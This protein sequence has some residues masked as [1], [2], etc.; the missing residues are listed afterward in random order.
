MRVVLCWQESAR[1]RVKDELEHRKGAKLVSEFVKYLQ[2][3][4]RNRLQFAV[5]RAKCEEIYLSVGF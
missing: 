3:E 5:L 2:G 4:E 1:A